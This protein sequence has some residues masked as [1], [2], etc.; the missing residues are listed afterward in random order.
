MPP[1]V[2]IIDR[3]RRYDRGIRV[4][5]TH[6]QAVMEKARICLL[7]AGPTG[8]EALKNLVLG[9][10]QS[11]TIVDGQKV[12]PVDLGNN[13]LVTA[14]GLVTPRAQCVTECLKEL[15]ETV[16]GSYVEE[17]PASLISNNPDFFSSF[18]LVIGTQLPYSVAIDLDSLCRQRDIP[19]IFARSYGLVGYLRVRLYV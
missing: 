2:P 15:N 6:G 5:G 14:S 19:L 1:V 17:D 11:F 12:Q 4:W 10:I 18:D 13:Y 9:G 7:N 3:Q 8:S 16:T